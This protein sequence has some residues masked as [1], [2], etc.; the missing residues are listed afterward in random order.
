LT[1][2]SA[3]AHAYIWSKSVSQFSCHEFPDGFFISSLEVSLS[4]VVTRAFFQIPPNNPLAS[5]NQLQMASG[6]WQSTATP[7]RY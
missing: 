4:L 5:G 1:I 2:S 6:K 3:I 7:L